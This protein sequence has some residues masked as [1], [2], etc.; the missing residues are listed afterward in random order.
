MAPSGEGELRIGWNVRAARRSRGMSL[1]A[2]AGLTGRSKGWLSK[3]ENGHARLERRQDIAANR[4]G[5]WWERRPLL[6]LLWYL[7]PHPLRDREADKNF[8][9]EARL[10]AHVLTLRLG[11][12][13]SGA[14][15]YGPCSPL[16]GCCGPRPPGT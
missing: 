14:L 11:G 16:S 7:S 9:R 5:R 8:D 4:T 3:V 10:W 12:K 1:D 2:L 15:W 13:R 6:L